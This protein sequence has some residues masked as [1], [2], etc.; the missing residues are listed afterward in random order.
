METL[1]LTGDRTI[2]ASFSELSP[3]LPA[4]H[5]TA[6]MLQCTTEST[7]GS[8]RVDYLAVE[9]IAR[10]IRNQYIASLLGRAKRAWAN[11][12]RA[13]SATVD[14]VCPVMLRP[15][16]HGG[17]FIGGFLRRLADYISRLEREQREAYLAGAI[18]IYDLERRMRELENPT[19]LPLRLPS[20]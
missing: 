16:Q 20:P 1:G 7:V 2:V 13:Q 19:R 18:D 5:Y 3:T 8:E 6:G 15:S 10:D 4:P 12:F 14:R 17:N 9:R 11:R